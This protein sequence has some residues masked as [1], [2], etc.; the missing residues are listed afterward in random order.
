MAFPKRTVAVVAIVLALGA[1]TTLAVRARGVEVSTASASRRD[2]DHRIVASGRVLAPSRVSV[3]ATTS[4][5]V[6]AV[7]AALGQHVNVGDLLVQTDDAEARAALAQSKAS[8]EQANARVAQLRHVGAIVANES[9]IQAEANLDKARVDFDRANKLVASGAVP[10]TELETAHR[11]LDLASAQKNAS[12]AQQ[13]AA[14]PMGA[15]SRVALGALLQAQAQRTG[16]EV[17]VAQS[18]ILATS[19]GT[20]LTRSVEP[21]DVV[22]PARTLLTIA[23]DGDVQLAFHADERN[24]AAIALGQKAVAS[25]DAFPNEVFDAEVSYIAPSID[26]QRGT[27]EIRLKVPK[28]PKYLRP[29]MTV[30]VDL[31][32]ASKRG[33]LVVPSEAVRAAATPTPWVLAVVSGKAVRK[34]VKIGIYGEGS[35]E[36]VSGIDEDQELILPDGRAIAVGRRVRTTRKEN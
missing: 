18:R 34:E 3:S 16:A 35:M 26:P 28:P 21:G 5:L 22:Q 20:V 27:V 2:L 14:A 19:A 29:D 24:L 36:I 30:S 23:V 4:G 9:L 10:P 7:G 32:V 1:G 25:A 8:V 11:A 13:V 17:R 31:L 15:D 33:A 6:V 12:E